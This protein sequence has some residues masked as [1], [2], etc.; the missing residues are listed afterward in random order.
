MSLLIKESM[1]FVSNKWQIMGGNY[2][3]S[4]YDDELFMHF[5]GNL[6]ILLLESELRE[7]KR[8]ANKELVELVLKHF[9]FAQKANENA[10]VD[11]QEEFENRLFEI[12]RS[13]TAI[14]DYINKIYGEYVYG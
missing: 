14:Y 2:P 4:F 7:I 12:A 9:N 6:D 3:A 11:S 10:F 13:R 1:D 8:A 5:V